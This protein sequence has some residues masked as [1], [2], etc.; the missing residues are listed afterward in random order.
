MRDCS[1]VP[2]AGSGTDHSVQLGD[3]D[4]GWG[5]VWNEKR[6]LGFAIEW[7]LD[8]FPHAWSW[9][10]AGGA[11]HYPLWGQGHLI[12]L[13]PSTSPVGRFTDLLKRKEVL[14][15]PGRGSVTTVMTTGFVTRANGPWKGEQ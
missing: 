9:N 11:R 14:W 5:C 15:V 12:T 7:E 3:F 1:V 6:Q 4:A 13:Q 8:K 10:L 2:P